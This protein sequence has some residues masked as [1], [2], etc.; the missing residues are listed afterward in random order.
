MASH[1]LNYLLQRRRERS[2]GVILLFAAMAFFTLA[3]VVLAINFVPHPSLLFGRPETGAP[4]T[5]V[6]VVTLEDARFTLPETIV[7]KID[8]PV[9]GE[10]KRIDL[11]IPWPFDRQQLNIVHALPTDLQNWV[12]ITLEP[13]EGRTGLEE[14]MVPIYSVYLDPIE[15]QEAGLVLRKFRT[16]SPY[17]DSELLVAPTG[18][19]IRCDK[20]PSVLGPIICERFWPVSQGVMARVRFSRQRL[21]EWKD[22]DETAQILLKEFMR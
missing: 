15:G 14:R 20:T 18:E 22:I 16:D 10:A 7:A 9:L 12:L 2:L 19:V 8:K 6:V 13:R 3:G 17:T 4:S 5:G 21:T 1:H 11:Q